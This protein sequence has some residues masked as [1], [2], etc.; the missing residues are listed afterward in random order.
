MS[1][2]IDLPDFKVTRGLLTQVRLGKGPQ[3]KALRD[4]LQQ[5]PEIREHFLR[6]RG[7]AIDNE[8]QRERMMWVKDA[9]SRVK[10]VDTNFR[11]QCTY[12][13]PMH[14]RTIPDLAAC[15]RSLPIIKAQQAAA[16]Q[17]ATSILC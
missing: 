1:H 5:H 10:R 11:R 12:T 8:K 14:T 6:E 7:V 9:Q 2:S 3:L 16:A 17:P 15:E 4:A 13:N